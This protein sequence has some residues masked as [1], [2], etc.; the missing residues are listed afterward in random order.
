[1]EGGERRGED[2]IKMVEN[3]VRNRYERIEGVIRK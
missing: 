3:G 2:E 1:M